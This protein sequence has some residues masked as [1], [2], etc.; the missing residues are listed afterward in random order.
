MSPFI[1]LFRNQSVI[2]SCVIGMQYEILEYL[3]KDTKK[4]L[5][6]ESET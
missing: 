3:V 1:K 4:G 6:N 5:N 2:D